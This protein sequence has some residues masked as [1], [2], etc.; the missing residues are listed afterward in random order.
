MQLSF[1][2]GQLVTNGFY[3]FRLGGAVTTHIGIPLVVMAF[4]VVAM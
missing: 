3:F 2:I 1:E 4:A